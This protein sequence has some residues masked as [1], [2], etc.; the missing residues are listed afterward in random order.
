MFKRNTVRPCQLKVDA[1]LDFPIV[2][3][4]KPVQS[5]LSLA[6]NYGKCQPCCA[7]IMLSLTKLLKRNIRFEW[8]VAA[9]ARFLDPRSRYASRPIRKP[10][11]YDIVLCVAVEVQ[12]TVRE[13]CC[14]RFLMDWNIR[15]ASS[16]E[17]SVQLI[18]TTP[19]PGIRSLS[20]G[21]WNWNLLP[22][23]LSRPSMTSST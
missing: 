22:D 17:G 20:D 10:P 7:N 8:S 1:L 2:T 18:S 16:T 13:Q 4:W 5:L 6:G 23:L 11:K 9:D 14:F 15:S 3:N 19:P 12:I 21:L